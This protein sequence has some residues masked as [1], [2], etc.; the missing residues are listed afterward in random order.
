ASPLARIG[1]LPTNGFTFRLIVACRGFGYSI[2]EAMSRSRPIPLNPEDKLYVLRQLD[3]FRFWQSLDDQ[4][5]CQGCNQIISGRSIEIVPRP[6]SPGD[7]LLRCPTT[8][9]ISQPNN[10]TYPDA[11]ATAKA[12]SASAPGTTTTG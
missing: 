5:H 8:D 9:C 1:I 3:E 2:E 4:R 6:G 10:W 11:I 7:F 12:L